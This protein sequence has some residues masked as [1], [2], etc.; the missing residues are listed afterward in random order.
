MKNP[1]PMYLQDLHTGVYG[2]VAAA[3]SVV[4]AGKAQL[5]P[6]TVSPRDWGMYD[7]A[8]S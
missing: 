6:T 1:M 7:V 4:V 8:S 3:G 2:A 5:K